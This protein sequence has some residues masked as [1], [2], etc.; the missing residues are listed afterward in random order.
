MATSF[1]TNSVTRLHPN[2][3]SSGTAAGVAAVMMSALNLS[4]AQMAA[5][6]S[7]LQDRLRSLGVPLA[8]N[9]TMPEGGD[10]PAGSA[11]P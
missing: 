8:F 10:G 9:L 7:Q 5:D 11:A 2:E 4:S 6:V 1:L 3:W